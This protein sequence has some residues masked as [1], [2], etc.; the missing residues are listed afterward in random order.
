MEH[1]FIR[2]NIT[3]AEDGMTVKEYAG[4]LGISK[5]LLTDIKFGGGDLLI[6]GEHVTVK[7]VLREGDLLVVKFPEEQVSETLLAEPVPL[8]ILYE[9]EHVLVINK[10]P[11]VSSIPSR[12]HPSGSIANGIIHHYQKNGVRATVHLVT[13]LD[14]DTSGVMLV[15]KHRFAHSILSSAQKNGLVK[16]RY[17][18]VVHGR[19]TGEGTVDAPIGRHPDSIIERRV[20]PDGQKAVTHFYVTRATDDITSVTLQLETG[21]TH[22]IR[23]HMSYLGHPLCGDTLYGGT[24]QK[25]GRQALH[26]EHL[27]FIHPLTQENMTFH[28]ALPQDMK[29]LTKS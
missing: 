8:D 20:T 15:A 7:Y 14:R 4:V 21:R 3:S 22:Q 13:R 1:F 26:S 17:A 16:R 18:A 11:Y 24:R 12:E 28:A 5:R 27:S 29:E 9:D 23:V 19:M 25:I 10:Q 2:K 6:N